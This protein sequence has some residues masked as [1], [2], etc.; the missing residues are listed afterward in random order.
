MDSFGDEPIVAYL[1]VAYHCKMS[2]LFHQYV[3]FQ[4]LTTVIMKG[5]ATYVLARISNSIAP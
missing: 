5:R 1:N 4:V 3:R 2:E